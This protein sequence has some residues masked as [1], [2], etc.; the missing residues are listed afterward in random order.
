ML[1]VKNAN[2]I[3]VFNFKEGK[4]RDKGGKSKALGKII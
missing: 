4:S 3:L 2:N 1:I